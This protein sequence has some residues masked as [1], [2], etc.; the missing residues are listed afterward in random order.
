MAPHNR[1]MGDGKKDLVDGSGP[2]LR[3]FNWSLFPDPTFVW[4]QSERTESD[5]GI[6]NSLRQKS[7]GKFE[8]MNGQN[9]GWITGCRKL[10]PN[11]EVPYAYKHIWDQTKSEI[12]ANTL[13]LLAKNPSK[14]QPSETLISQSA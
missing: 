8:V 7:T 12:S 14:F 11:D 6:L 9:S 13:K 5:V 4:Q 1:L 2:W 10:K 3:A